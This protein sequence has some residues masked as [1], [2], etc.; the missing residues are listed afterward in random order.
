[1]PRGAS[2]TER[3]YMPCDQHG[4][5]DGASSRHDHARPDA[6][7]VP[8][9]RSATPTTHLA[10]P[11]G[12]LAALPTMARRSVRDS[13]LVLVVD[14][15]DPR[16]LLHGTLDRLDHVLTAARSGAVA[17]RAALELSGGA[18]LL[19][20][21]GPPERVDP[22]A[23]SFLA[24]AA[25]AGLPVL[26]AYRA[27]GDRFWS[28]LCEGEGCCP[29]EG[30]PFDP[31]ARATLW[32]PPGLVA[33]QRPGPPRRIDRQT[34]KPPEEVEPEKTDPVRIRALLEP[35]V[36][37]QREAV[38]EAAALLE[39]RLR[40]ERGR[41]ASRSRIRQVR[42][43]V[44]RETS[45]RVRAPYSMAMLGVAVLDLRVRD[46]VWA[47]I[48][49]QE[50]PLHRRLWSR[51][52]RHVPDR[53]RAGPAS[54]LAVAAWQTGDTALARAAVQSALAA[55]PG[56]A[57]AVLM[58]RALGWGLSAERWTRH[59]AEHAGRFELEGGPGEGTEPGPDRAPP[60]R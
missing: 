5:D 30:S 59:M 17:V 52:T 18:A 35:V 10:D 43:V 25:A 28:Y 42:S 11:R 33:E 37:E 26:A 27:T 22:H 1:M 51:V 21:F 53:H 47:R 44:R 24:E 54:L 58:E 4:P 49:P 55:R 20:G 7:A 32:K 38:A 13:V 3:E 2:V 36:G 12:F 6:R 31:Q 40:A 41:D 56:Y 14:R 19:A 50:A 39:A 15:G 45:E 48:T 23:G 29:A 34:V 16:G 8:P 60:P 57:M 9:P 46:A